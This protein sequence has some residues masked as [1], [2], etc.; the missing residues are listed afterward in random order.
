M[1]KFIV[2]MVSA[3]LLTTGVFAEASLTVDFAT[4]HI[5]RGATIT[6]DLVIQPGMELS[7]FG[8][9]E[10]YG[11][12]AAGVWGSTAPFND[13][14]PSLDSIYE[15]DWYL[16]YALP[17]LV[18]G[19]DL[20]IQYTQYQYSFTPDE[21]ELNFGIGYALGDFLLGAT[22]NFMI[23]DRNLLTENQ[24]YF[25][26][27]A[28]YEWEINEKSAVNA[29]GLIAL[30][31]QGDGYSAIG[32]DDGFNH[33][34]LDAAYSYAMSEMWSI[35]ATIGYVGQLDSNVLPDAFYD[36][37]LYAMLNLGCEL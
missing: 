10:K 17:Q 5:F 6:D 34:E 4:A 28:D 24:K 9:N 20:Y 8:M 36:R 18:E 32:L 33:Y 26:F 35:G 27:F 23:D 19:M 11:V 21:K 16:N 22:A 25:D 7:G 15:T 13:D 29:G 2:G 30:M 12:F 37:G 31:F 14:T 3:G 1:K